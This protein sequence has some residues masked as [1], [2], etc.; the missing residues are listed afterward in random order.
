[1]APRIAVVPDDG[2]IVRRE[3]KP[4]FILYSEVDP[5][6][7][8]GWLVK[9]LLGSGEASATYGV[10]GSG[11]S[12]LI[13]DMGLH[14]AAGEPWHGRPVQSGAVM[15]VALERFDLVKRRSAAFR[16]KHGLDNLPFA[17][18]GGVYDFREPS[19]SAL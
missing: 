12:A 16:I 2:E 17:M 1:M 3:R 7:R 6:I 9:G 4:T 14:I 13:E 15:Y 8:K 11:K 19:T 18:L 5:G 10:A